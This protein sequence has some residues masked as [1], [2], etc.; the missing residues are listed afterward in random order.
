MRDAAEKN[1]DVLQ[2]IEFAIVDVFRAD[3]S[4]LDID[5]KEAMDALVRHYH[6]EQEQRTPPVRRLGD[7]S[8]RVFD[9]VHDMC[10][11]RL[12]RAPLRGFLEAG[13][14]LNELLE[15]LRKIQKSVVFWSKEGGRHGYLQFV[16]PFIK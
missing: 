12:G 10:E 15:C 6:A 13:I 14:P 8:Q 1:L 16:S 5:V 3:G 7:R 2:N 11:W 9:A 4:L